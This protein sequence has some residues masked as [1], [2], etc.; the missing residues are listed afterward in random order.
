ML[1]KAGLSDEIIRGRG[2]RSARSQPDI[3]ALGFQPRQGRAPALVIPIWGRD[4]QTATHLIRPDSPRSKDGRPITFELPQGT[5]L[6]IDVPARCREGVA[7]VSKELWIVDGPI[8]A[9]AMATKGFNS[10]AL[11]GSRAWRHLR[12]PGRPVLPDLLDI[13][14]QGR[15][16]NTAFRSDVWA[17]PDARGDVHQLTHFLRGRGAIVLH[18]ILPPGPNAECQGPHDLLARGDDIR[19]L[20]SDPSS[21]DFTYGAEYQGPWGE[22]DRFSVTPEGT[23]RM[24]SREN[25]LVPVQ[26]ANFSAKIVTEFHITDGADERIEFELEVSLKGARSIL[27]MTADEFEAMGW[28][29][30]YLGADAIVTSGFNVR[31]DFREAIQ[32]FSDAVPRTIVFTNLGWVRIGDNWG[33]LHAGGVIGTDLQPT[34]DEDQEDRPHRN[35]GAARALSTA[36]PNTPILEQATP[37]PHIRVKVPPLFKNFRLP[38]PWTGQRAIAAVRAT[39]R[40]LD[41]GPDRIVMPLFAAPFRAVVDETNFSLFVHGPT[42]CF[43]SELTRLVTQFFGPEI[44]IEDLRGWNSTANAL[45]S[46]AFLAKNV[47]FPVD[48][49][50][51]CGT[52]GEIL[53]ANKQVD[54]LLRSQANRSARHRSRGDGTLREGKPPRGLILST[55]EMLPAGQSLNARLLAIGIEEGDVF[56]LHDPDKIARINAAQLSAKTGCYAQTMAQFIQWLA[57]TY[58]INRAVMHQQKADFREVF[59]E[60][61]VHPRSVDIAADLAAGLDQFLDFAHE[62]GAVDETQHASL[63]ERFHVAMWDLLREQRDQVVSEDPVTRYLELLTSALHCGRAHLKLLRPDEDQSHVA[64]SPTLWGYNEKTI[65]VPRPAGLTDSDHDESEEEQLTNRTILV[66][67]GR[68]VGW[69]DYDNLYIDPDASLAVVNLFARELA[70]PEIPFPKKT[71][72]KRLMDRGL[73]RNHG[74]DRNTLKCNVEGVRREV[75]N[76][77]TYELVDLH[78]PE[79]DYVEVIQEELIERQAEF[80]GRRIARERVLEE[81]R[82]RMHERQQKDFIKLLNLCPDESL[83][84]TP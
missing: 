39:L 49:F 83:N 16:V 35:S 38:E 45:A 84:E 3:Q 18:A 31:D 60:N 5:P 82:K 22:R 40:F 73:I 21:L 50:I 58:E 12:K 69:K 24:T 63:W 8:E 19:N 57:P 6:T 1:N 34:V 25:D 52:R 15:S 53:H 14:L 10:V 32:R 17:S 47:V 48:D 4:G 64:G 46:L 72:G 65:P 61:G 80:S 43:K 20:L 54:D 23:F 11:L 78:M 26:L 74:K 33:F 68:Q 81:R 42:G 62:I 44:S 13:P 27:C 77:R 29:L 37:T 41:L 28:P 79:V 59:Q 51:P 9:D 75:F 56:D 30:R 2:Y 66:P 36:G 7:D 71:L 76:L 70:V 55:G 67:R